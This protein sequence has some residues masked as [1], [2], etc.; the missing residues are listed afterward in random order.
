[1]KRTLSLAVAIA[2]L[3]SGVADAKLIAKGLRGGAGSATVT[4][5]EPTT[6]GD[7]TTA[8][9]IDH[10]NVKYSTTAGVHSVTVAVAAPATSKL[11]SSLAVGV[12]IYVVIT[13]VR[14][15]GAESPES[16][17]VSYTPS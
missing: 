11:L 17:E 13:S 6:L 5:R 14:T 2:L 4:W 15:G 9:D 10:Y 7:T 1:M 3:A 8:S 16:I 12:P